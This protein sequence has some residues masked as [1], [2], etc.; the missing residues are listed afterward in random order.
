MSKKTIKRLSVTDLL[1]EKEKYQVKDDVTETVIVERLGVEVVLRKPE[2]SLCVDTMKMTR[3]ENNDTDADEYMVYN[4]MVEPDLK[5][6][7]LQKAYGG[8]LPTDVV[9]KIFEPGEIAQLS[10]VAF[11]LAGY[12]KGGVKAIK[13]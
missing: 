8:T 7:E 6:P 4:T 13:N 2:K 3:D 9:S 12:K 11:E 10:E 1:K 5:D